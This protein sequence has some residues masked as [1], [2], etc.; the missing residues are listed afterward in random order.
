MRAMII[1][2]ATAIVG[3]SLLLKMLFGAALHLLTVYVAYQSVGFFWAAITFM[4]PVVA[5]IYWVIAIWA[6]TGVFLN[7]YTMACLVYLGIWVVIIF[8][9][10]IGEAAEAAR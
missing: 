9:T 8:A 4:F 5:E 1:G 10:S 2:M 7:L 3:L 6:E